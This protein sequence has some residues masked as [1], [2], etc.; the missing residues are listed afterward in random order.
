[1]M[2]I[3]YATGMWIASTAFAAILQAGARY[4]LF[5]WATECFI[6]LYLVLAM[7]SY[8]TIDPSRTS[9]S[10]LSAQ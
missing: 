5:F 1:M 2:C 9:K 4:N 6:A 10:E 8:G 7:K 3:A